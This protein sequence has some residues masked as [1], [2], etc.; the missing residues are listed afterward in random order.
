V[1]T[2]TQAQN[3]IVF[4]NDE[5]AL[6]PHVTGGKGSSLVDLV[7]NEYN[8]PELHVI[9]NTAY[10]V[11]EKLAGLENFHPRLDKLKMFQT[12]CISQWSAKV[13]KAILAVKLPHDLRV[14]IFEEAKKQ[15]KFN[16]YRSSM[17]GEDGVS[18]SY[19][20]VLKTELFVNLEKPE[21]VDA[22]YLGL[23]SEAFSVS[24]IKYRIFHN[25]SHN[26]SL[27][28]VV[29]KQID[30]YAGIVYYGQTQ[31]STEESL[32]SVVY[33]QCE[34]IVGNHTT[35][36]RYKANNSTFAIQQLEQSSQLKQY[37]PNFTTKK[38]EWVDVPTELQSTPPLPE[39]VLQQIVRIGQAEAARKG[40]PRDMEFSVTIENGEFVIWVL[41]SRPVTKK[42]VSDLGPEDNETEVLATGIPV[43]PGIFY[44]QVFRQGQDPLS[45]A[46]NSIFIGEEFGPNDDELLGDIGAGG[47]NVGDDASHG[48]AK[49][50]EFGIPFVL[51]AKNSDGVP[52]TQLVKS[53]E[54]I[55]VDGFLGKIYKGKSEIRVAWSE[56]LPPQEPINQIGMKTKLVV[57]CSYV[58]NVLEA[59]RLGAAGI[60]LLRGDFF[61][62]EFPLAYIGGRENEALELI[63]SKLMQSAA[64]FHKMWKES[65]GKLGKVVYRVF[66]PKLQ[67]MRDKQGSEPWHSTLLRDHRDPSTGIQ[68][69]SLSLH[70]TYIDAFILE[71]LAFKKAWEMY[72]NLVLEFPVVR[73]ED[74]CIELMDILTEVGLNNPEDRPRRSM[75]AELGINYTQPR[76]F[77]KYFDEASMGG[78]DSRLSL[79]L[80]NRDGSEAAYRYFA[81]D[82]LLIQTY[83]DFIA[84]CNEMGIYVS[85]CGNLPS[86]KP[87]VCKQFVEAGIS[88]ISVGTHALPA[89]EKVVRE[90]EKLLSQI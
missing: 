40:N 58:E 66:G 81:N 45:L 64:P 46:K 6:Y 24:A 56:Q 55:T 19:A 38:C 84:V 9:S 10:S 82:P 86:S 85:F 16:S 18:L 53:G 23:L 5:I 62:K 43:S 41:Q 63:S 42:L 78:N 77:L 73:S 69:L 67:E 28:I 61:W 80:L 57:N 51:S 68:G 37:L 71:L 47:A 90:T 8:V 70:P 83:C 65:G 7:Q 2:Q 49:G 29:Q 34:G 48:A 1:T 50:H 60:G 72:P 76:A 11:I 20:G 14:L 3:L 22:I 17:V 35:P 79:T 30:S 39:F 74:D 26:I 12:R 21:D 31:T 75:M 87:A 52:I 4:P 32:F 36:F 33:G 88:S 44:G 13:Q 89:A 27:P 54:L 15:S 59:V 25:V